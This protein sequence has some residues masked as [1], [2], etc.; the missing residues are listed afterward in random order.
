MRRSLPQP[1]R[2]LDIGCNIG[3]TTCFYAT[4]YPEATIIGVDR[5]QVV[6]ACAKKLAA[7]LHLTNVEFIEADVLN[8]RGTRKT[9]RAVKV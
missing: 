2:I 6:I 3:I 7:K 4:L 5:N 8:L 9:G 1:N